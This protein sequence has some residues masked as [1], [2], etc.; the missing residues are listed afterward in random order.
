MVLTTLKNGPVTLTV[1][2]TDP[3]GNPTVVTVNLIKDSTAPTGSFT[4]AGTTISGV[5]A[6]TNP[7][8]SLSLAFTAATGIASVAFST[9]GGSTYGVPQAYATAAT[10]TLGADGLY[11]I[12]IQVTSNAGNVAIFTKQVRLDRTGPAI[13]YSITAPT[14]SGSYDVGQVVTLTDS[15][16]DVDNVASLSAVLDGTTAITS[17]VAFN[18]ET[19]AAGT[20]TIVITAKDGLGNVSTTTLTLT[21]HA[22]I[23]GL[24]TA[25]NDGVTHS[26]IL[27]STVATQLKAYLSS[28]QSALTAGN[29]TLAKSYLASFVTYV[30]QQSG[31]TINAAY[32]ALLV[33]WAQDLISRL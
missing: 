15:A 13:S 32:A 20:H 7:A 28:A 5:V 14:N 30:Q 10:L 16:S 12:A 9:N 25:V 27:S 1:T 2:E 3:A 33:G 23:A 18:T 19:L 21:V 26:M 31:I 6:T 24:T 29:H 22:T 17:G 8:L 4:I 11:T